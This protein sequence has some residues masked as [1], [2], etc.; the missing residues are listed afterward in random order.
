MFLVQ[1]FT[2]DLFPLPEAK[3]MVLALR[4][5][6]PAYP[7]ALYLGDIGHP[8]ASN[9]AGE[10]GYVLGLIKGWLAYYLK[11]TGAAPP[12]VVYAARTRP[13]TEQFDAADVITVPTLDALATATASKEFMLPTV[14]V[15]PATTPAGGP[16]WD[17][18][19]MTGAQMLPYFPDEPPTP[20]LA[21]G[22][23]GIYNVPV[24]ELSRGGDL[25]IAGQPTVSFH[26]RS[27]S[28]RVQV[29]VR[30]FDVDPLGNKQL[31]TRGT[32]TIESKPL[33]AP[34]GDVDVTIATYGNFWRAPSGHTL[35]LELTN[36]DAPYIAPSRIPSAAT[37][38]GVRLEV[39]IR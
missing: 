10:V 20:S 17:P 2:D 30:L 18:L 19:V 21:E 3:R 37:L 34:I 25:T 15:N 1:G 5:I 8:R 9:K 32:Y 4:T 26:V 16:F 22:E 23:P 35:R 39:P 13:R 7:V 36:V 6:D 14:L 27:P 29:N 24:D 33:G 31:I 28:N 11:G 38:T 12:N